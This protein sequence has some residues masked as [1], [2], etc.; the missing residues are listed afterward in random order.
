MDNSRIMLKIAKNIYELNIAQFLS[1]YKESSRKN[2]KEFYRDLSESQ[3]IFMAEDDLVV[4]MRD[5][6]Q[7]KDSFCALWVVDGVYKS[8]L[9]IEPY[10]DGV[11]LH[12]LETAPDA[13]RMGYGYHLIMTVLEYLQTEE[14]KK[15]YS[16]IEKRNKPSLILHEKCGFQKITDSATY[17]DGTVT[18]NSCTMMITL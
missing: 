8:I 14:Y 5:F 12:A 7:Q 15:V 13:R 16:H 10:S 1:V 18:Q 3:Q 11:L 6:F 9:R 17:I 4:Y 2:G